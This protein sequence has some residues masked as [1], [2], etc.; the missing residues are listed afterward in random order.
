MLTEERHQKILQ[1]LS[2]QM[3]VK[4]Q[5]L[6]ALLNTSESTIRRDLK[7]LADANLLERI[8]GGA[9]LLLNLSFEQNMTEKA[10]QNNQEK[11]AIATLAAQNIHDNEIIYLDAGSTTLKLIPLL[12]DKKITVVTN[13]V[14]HAAKLVDLGIHTIILGG[15]LKLSTKAIVGA[16]SMEQLQRYRFNKV[17]IGMNA[18]H[19]EFGLTTPDSEEAALK[20]LAISQGEQTYVLADHTK[21]NQVSFIKVHSIEK[22]TLL[23]DHCS[24]EL[25][26][27]F[28]QITTIKEAT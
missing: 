1:L 9:R 28:Q 8:H 19:P 18:V 6:T 15:S 13:A 14:H 3:I 21:L 26:E 12:K 5:E 7:E 2:Q 23:T 4:T 17:F 25:L 24:S 10:D 20:S 11:K 22:V 27:Q 16:T